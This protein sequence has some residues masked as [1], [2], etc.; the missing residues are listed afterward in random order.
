MSSNNEHY[1]EA[2][3][4]LDQPLDAL[5]KWI[6]AHGPGLDR[7]HEESVRRAAHLLVQTAR[8]LKELAGDK[9]RA[10]STRAVLE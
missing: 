10:S 8:A 9:K 3:A 4:G 6:V 5:H 7:L 2:A 1:R